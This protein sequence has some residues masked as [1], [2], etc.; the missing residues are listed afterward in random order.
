V[1]ARINEP[2]WTIVTTVALGVITAIVAGAAI[3]NSSYITLALLMMFLGIVLYVG[4]F[5]QYTWQIALLCSYLGLF[6]WPAGFRIGP[7]ELASGLGLLLA[8]ITCW[9]KTAR[10]R[11]GVLHHRAF[12]ALRLLLLLWIVYVGIH[13]WYN[14]HNPLR[15]SEFALKNALKSYFAG[16]APIAILWYFSGNPQA[17]E[18]K[19]NVIRTIARL[20]MAGMIFNLAITWYGL[21]THHNVVDPDIE[22]RNLPAFLI[23]GLNAFENPYTLRE[24][25]PPAVLLGSI[26]LA[27]GSNLTRVSRRLSLL[28]V[29]VGSVSC[30]FSS[31]RSAIATSVA[32]V[33]LVLL[34]RKQIASFCLIVIATVVFVVVV[35]VSA[36]FVNQRLPIAMA[37][38]LQWVL[39]SKNDIAES[40]I[41]SSSGWRKELFDLAVAEWQSDSRI[42]WFGR[43]TYGFGVNDYVAMQVSSGWQASMDSSLRRGATHNLLTDLLVAYG[44][45][46]CLLYYSLALAIIWFLLV[47]YRYS[48][49]GT[50]IRPLSLFCLMNCGSYLVVATI[51]GGLYRIDAIWLVIVLIAALYR[52]KSSPE[53]HFEMYRV[54]A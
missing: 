9:N 41:E 20:L 10:V 28:L 14:V 39:L 23:P 47:V 37:R 22:T 42:F 24:L 6:Y 15:P 7:T 13:M 50:F 18:T 1:N 29:A 11:E 5:R 51:A 30:I 3:A 48:D 40:S 12:T 25:G 43:A 19:S 26:T 44:L 35:N 2:N 17:I 45:I 8:A 52:V 36:D 27:F 21:L 31:G 33:M 49:K 38:P 32:F 34:V 53:H 16:L 46:G 54:T 4:Y